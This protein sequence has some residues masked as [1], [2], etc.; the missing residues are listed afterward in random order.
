MGGDS[1]GG[2]IDIPNEH[3]DE[4]RDIS[5]FLKE[6]HYLEE[7]EMYLNQSNL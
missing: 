1:S 3:E 7:E 4:E 6:K 2:E 5:L